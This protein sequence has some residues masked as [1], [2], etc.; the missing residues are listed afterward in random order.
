[1]AQVSPGVAM[2]RLLIL[3]LAIATGLIALVFLKTSSAVAQPKTVRAEYGSPQQMKPHTKMANEQTLGGKERYLTF[4][5]TDKP[6]YRPGEKVYVRGVIL[7]AA[8]HKPMPNNS[9]NATIEIEGPKGD[10]IATGSA[11]AADSVWGFAWEVPAEQAGGEYTA[12]VTYPWDGHAPSERKFEIRAYRAPRLKSQITFL[13]DGYGSGD[14]VQATLDVKRAEGGVPQGAKVTVTA[15]VDGSPINGG[16][17]TV[18]ADGLSSVSIDLPGEIPRGEGTLALIIEDGG[19]VETASK[20]IPILLQ[21]VDLEILPEGGDLLAAYPNRVYIQAKQPNGKPADL[22][23]KVISGTTRAP[24]A[25]FRTEHEGRGRFEFT[26]QANTEYYLSIS[27][28][29]GLKRQ[30]PLPQ[31]RPSGALIRSASD[32]FE[33]NQPV[34]VNVGCTDNTYTVTVSKRE[35]ELSACKVDR[36]KRTDIKNGDLL[37][38]SFDL[39]ADVDG[40]L[41]VTIWDALDVPIAERLV[42]RQPAKPIKISVAAE[43]KAYVPGDNAKV[44]VKA[45]DADGKPVS[46]VVGVTVTDDTVLE[47]IEKREQAPRLPVMVFL[48]PEVNDLADAHVYLDSTNAKAPLATDLLLGTQGWRRFALMELAK[49][50]A[51]NGDDGRRV[52]ALKMQTSLDRVEGDMAFFMQGGGAGGG[53]GEAMEVAELA[54]AEPPLAGNAVALLPPA[55][56]ANAPVVPMPVG[57]MKP[58]AKQFAMD[59]QLLPGNERPEQDMAQQLMDAKAKSDFESALVSADKNAKSKK[60]A[61]DKREAGVFAEEWGGRRQA[62]SFVLVREFA[63]QVRKDRKPTDRVDFE[64][65]LYW[66][67]GIKTDAK[68]GEATINFG[69]NDSVSTFRVFADAFTGDGA[70]G[71]A[72]AGIESVQPFYAEAKLP[73]EVTAGDQIL[74]PISLINATENPLS[75]AVLNVDLKGDFKLAS[76]QGS[77]AILP[78]GSRERWIQPIDV[79]VKNGL[80]AF[81]LTANAGAFEDKVTRNLVVKPKGF[82]IEKTFGGMIGPDAP[83]IHT[84]TIPSEMAPASLATNSAVYPT[85]LAN[86]TEALQRL[87]QDPNGCFEQTCSTS[88]PLT[89]AQQYFLSHT[90]V[91]PKLVEESRKKLDSGYKMLVSYWC[92]DKGYEWFGENPGHEALTAFGLMHFTDMAQ[93]REVDQNMVA[94]TRNWLV[95]QRDGQGGFTR[96]RRSL[97]TWVEDKDCSNAYIVWCLL[98]TGQPAADLKPELTSLKTAST[99]SQDSYVLALAANGLHLA[100]D[101][102]EAKKLMDR[103]AEK[104][105]E[106]GSVSGIKHSIVASEGEALMIEGVSLAT[107]AWMRDPAYAGNVERGIKFLA[108]SCKAGRY[109]STQSTVLALRAIVTYDKLRARP[110]APGKVRIFVDGQPI[111]DWA[112]FNASTQGAIKLPDLSELLTPGQHK[113]EIRMDGGAPMPYSIAVKYNAITPTSDDACKIALNVRMA[114]NQL[115]EGAATEAN[116]TVINKTKAVLPT[117]IAII[118]LPGGLEPRHDQLKE[119]V[120]KGKIDAYEVR[121]REVVLYWRAMAA[122]AKL[123]IPLSLIA[124]VP[125]TYTGPASRAYLYYTDEHKNWVD[126]VQ[127][128]IAAK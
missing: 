89:M 39:P 124:A 3:A 82:P 17:T 12:R 103:L 58:Q 111:G 11:Q 97:H 125:G 38:V 40:V 35:K 127:V 102:V 113:L 105:K 98:E 96:K 61:F 19:V 42:F 25:E 112:E 120:K 69:L 1:M 27:E 78:A 73:L 51:I 70:V 24:V 5:S 117:P 29:A 55:M 76:V 63:H 43:K 91:D 119:L 74:L 6:V 4:M 20:T 26:P 71:A 66:N 68:T 77:N 59:D 44:T 80:S 122:D 23:G 18:G 126:G 87:I 49:F 106:D 114:Q 34:V 22:A 65:T 62:S 31:V 94:T 75:S 46:A 56:P 115:L 123:E 72:N 30:Y 57:A 50:L 118:G 85:P 92:P 83:V 86:L 37:P 52:V 28:P 53:G 10:S 16:T 54:P 33:K 90:G 67:A 8:N 79:G 84:I 107:L 41:T 116:V 108:D 88:Y 121:G 15:L 14:K 95:N 48:E 104:Q 36:S 64:E 9:A 81:V 99:N 45:T 93:V 109:G 7:D 110:K 2:S 13:R 60:I 21:T 32:I 100:G 47:M 101:K 128:Q